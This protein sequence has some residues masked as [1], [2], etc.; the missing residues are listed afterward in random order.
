MMITRSGPPTTHDS[1]LWRVP[2]SARPSAAWQ[3][4]FQ[5]VPDAPGVISPR[6]VQFEPAALTFRSDDAHVPA[7]VESID[8]WI[9][10][11]NRVQA[12]VADSVQEQ[13]ARARAQTDARRQRADESN[14]K[15]KNL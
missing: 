5:S 15:F 14:E 1:R 8:R 2:L 12:A 13:S 10:D 11:A 7:W 9:A 4:S 6:L 3:Q